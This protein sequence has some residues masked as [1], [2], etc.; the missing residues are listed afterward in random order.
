MF[1]E[2]NSQNYMEKSC[3]FYNVDK[4][5]NFFS[6]LSEIVMKIV[7]HLSLTFGH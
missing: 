4:E 7:I 3:N 5:A 1:E 6:V 2:K